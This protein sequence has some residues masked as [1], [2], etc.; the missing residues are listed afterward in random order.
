MY[1]V[2]YEPLVELFRIHSFASLISLINVLLG[3]CLRIR[4]YKYCMKIYIMNTMSY[5]LKH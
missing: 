2:Q 1:L 4:G 3:G 5:S